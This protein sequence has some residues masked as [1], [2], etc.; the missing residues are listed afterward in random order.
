LLEAERALSDE[1]AEQVKAIESHWK[2]LRE[3]EK[4]NEE[5][6]DAGRI[7]I[8]DVLESRFYRLQAEIR[9]ER[10]RSDLTKPDR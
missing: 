8:Q 10:A 1:R 4:V 5:R 6:F 9:L 2:R 7:P 3:I